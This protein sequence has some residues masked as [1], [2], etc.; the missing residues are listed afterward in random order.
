MLWLK[1]FVESVSDLV[2]L[3]KI[4]HIRG[5]R[6]RKGCE[7]KA[8]GST[9]RHKKNV[10]TINLKIYDII[11]KQYKGAIISSILDTLAHELAHVK[12]GFEHSPEHYELT[13]RIALKFSYLLKQNGIIDTSLRIDN[14]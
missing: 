9:I 4:T 14:D 6:V 2:S 13:S 10:Y 8:Y 1:P 12:T 5:Y 7:V 3:K 11:N